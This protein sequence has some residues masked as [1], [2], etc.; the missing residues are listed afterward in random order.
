VVL[1]DFPRQSRK[2]DRIELDIPAQFQLLYYAPDGSLQGSSAR[3]ENNMQIMA[4]P[5]SSMSFQVQPYGTVQTAS[6]VDELN[7]NAQLKLE[8]Q[9]QT[10]T[11]IPM[12]AGLELGQLEEPAFDR[13]SLILCRRED[14]SLWNIAKRC[15]STVEEIQRIN[16][17]EG[18]PEPN[19]MLLIPVL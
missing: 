13:P 3:W 1:P 8:M 17:L 10:L 7:L 19:R 14:Q 18:Q 6:G 2:G 12:V 4:D 9:T 16:R 11:G 5:D 15:G